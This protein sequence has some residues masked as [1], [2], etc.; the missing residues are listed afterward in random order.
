M[1]NGRSK[2]KTTTSRLI[3]NPATVRTVF[4]E[5]GTYLQ[6]KFLLTFLQKNIKIGIKLLV[7]WIYLDA[8]GGKWL[9]PKKGWTYNA[10]PLP[11]L[12]TYTRHTLVA[13]YLYGLLGPQGLRVMTPIVVNV[14]LFSCPLAMLGSYLGNA[15]LVKF[16]VGLMC[17]LHVG[18]SFTIRNSVLLSY[19]ACTA[20]S[21]FLPIG[22]DNIQ[23]VTQKKTKKSAMSRLG[24][25]ISLV[26]VGGM[27]ASNIWFENGGK[28]CSTASLR[29]IWSTLLQNRWNVF[30]GA[31][32]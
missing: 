20:W 13:Q 32:E 6:L 15:W 14:E 24:G 25:M 19:I 18:I 16:A 26:L 1:H 11:A 30:I 29:Q 3:V 22:W 28:D 12:D 7:F 5:S 8:G 2:S 10:S 23:P 17:H 31:E 21:V 9:D 4:L 27:A